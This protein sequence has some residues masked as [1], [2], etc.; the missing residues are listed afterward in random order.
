MYR[1]DTGILRIALPGSFSFNQ[2]DL[3]EFLRKYG[4]IENVVIKQNYK[5]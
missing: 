5:N 2:N 3:E 1:E 4:K